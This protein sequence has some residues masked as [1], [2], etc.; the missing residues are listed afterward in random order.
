MAGIMS[1]QE[2][3][4][5]DLFGGYSF[6]RLKT[7]TDFGPANLNGW[8]SSLAWNL[9]SWFSVA[10]EGSGHY[11]SSTFSN[12]VVIFICTPTSCT[13]TSN[14]GITSVDRKFHSY[15]FGPQ[16]TW[17]T[18]HALTPF[19]HAQIGAFH[20]SNIEDGGS[21]KFTEHADRFL[22]RTGGGV[23]LRLNS[24]ASWRTQ[25]DWLRYRL[26]AQRNSLEVST[27]PVFHFGRK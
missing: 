11:G 23:A 14:G 3:S 19:A 26:D 5:F 24:L 15:T 20:V 17:R 4:K 21:F 12:Q 7:S 9:N 2:A 13:H 22:L 25:I 27:G 16:F 18:G 10:G 6:G 8:D 1:A